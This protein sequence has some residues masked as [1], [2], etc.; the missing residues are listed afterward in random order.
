MFEIQFLT[1][2]TR[3]HIRKPSLKTTI[4]SE[5][6]GECLG[7]QQL[8]E[9]GRRITIVQAI[10]QTVRQSDTVKPFLKNKR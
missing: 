7:A 1:I 6:D 5:C 9:R 3:I 4:G 2:E 8:G 10:G